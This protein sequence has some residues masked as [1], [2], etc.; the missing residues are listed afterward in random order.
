MINNLSYGVLILLA[1]GVLIWIWGHTG[2]RRDP[3]QGRKSTRRSSWIY[4]C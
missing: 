4:Q 3:D 2:K 1:A